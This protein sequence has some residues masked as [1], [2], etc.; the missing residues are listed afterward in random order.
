MH[1]RTFM[2]KES[3]ALAVFPGVRLKIS[4]TVPCKTTRCSRPLYM[5]NSDTREKTPNA[6]RSRG[7]SGQKSRTKEPIDSRELFVVRPVMTR[8]CPV[9]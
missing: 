5:H 8:N 3:K 2:T 1:Q 9:L 7:V 6:K 4:R